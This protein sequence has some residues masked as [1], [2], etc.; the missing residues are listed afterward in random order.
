MI[1]HNIS[2]FF[3]LL[4]FIPFLSACWD[5]IAIDERAY[6]VALGLGKSEDENKIQVTFLI[7][8]PELSKKKPE[9]MSLL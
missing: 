2:K 5:Q 9:P 1:R 7:T 8:N 6:V 4:L 3:C